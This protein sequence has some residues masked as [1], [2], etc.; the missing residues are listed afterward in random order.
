MQTK[1]GTLAA[2]LKNITKM[3]YLFIILLLPTLISAQKVKREDVYMVNY[4]QPSDTIKI[5][6]SQISFVEM[7]YSYKVEHPTNKLI[8][9]IDLKNYKDVFKKIINDSFKDEYSKFNW[10]TIFAIDYENLTETEQ[11]LIE[12]LDQYNMKKNDRTFLREYKF[13]DGK[14]KYG[15]EI[16]KLSSFT[17]YYLKSKSE[18]CT[19]FKC[20]K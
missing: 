15:T 17:V 1:G 14:A 2:S 8:L 19:I 13:D 16:K 6:K 5:G 7:E 12:L 9:F 3:K 10:F 20:E 11:N 18:I 4:I